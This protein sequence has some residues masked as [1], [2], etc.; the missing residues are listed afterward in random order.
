[1]PTLF[2]N[3]TD[4]QQRVFHNIQGIPPDFDEFD[5]LTNNSQARKYAHQISSSNISAKSDALHYNA[6]DFIFMQNSWLATRFGNGTY[7]VWYSSI[8]LHTSFYETLY[9]WK[10][11]FIDSPQNFNT[12]SIKTLRTVF[13]IECNAALIDLRKKV[14]NNKKLIHPDPAHYTYTQKIGARIHR[15]GYP[16]LITKSARVHNGENIVI[17]KKDILSSPTHEND[18]FYEVDSA[19]NKILIKQAKSN[20]IIFEY[21]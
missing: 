5:D 19:D 10:K 9:H 1:M 12:Q 18:Y 8:D 21:K 15:E 7:P 11:T 3:L 14:T 2:T 17:F 16:G 4:F 20:K 13:T 6:I